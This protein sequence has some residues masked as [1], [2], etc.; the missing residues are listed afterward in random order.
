MS[1]RSK[2]SFNSQITTEA[3]AAKSGVGKPTIYRQ[4]A[5]ASELAMAALMSGDAGDFEQNATNLRSALTRQ[6]RSLIRAFATT[7]GAKSP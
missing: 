6:M 5:N 2:L 4:W 7:R 1:T 3:V